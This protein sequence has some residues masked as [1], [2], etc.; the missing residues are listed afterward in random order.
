[1][2]FVFV[3]LKLAFAPTMRVGCAD[4]RDPSGLLSSLLARP[5]LSSPP[6]VYD[7]NILVVAAMK[8]GPM[9][10]GPMVPIYVPSE[11]DLSAECGY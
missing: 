2:H 6:L 3:P 11:S 1:M 7:T 10:D 8:T 5:P 4:S 9:I